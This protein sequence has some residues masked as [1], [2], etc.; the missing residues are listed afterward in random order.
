VDE[1][2]AGAVSHLCKPEERGCVDLFDFAAVQTLLKGGKVFVVE[3]DAVAD[4][5]PIAAV[6]RY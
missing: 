2:K 6:F 3:D 5:S 4:G 1:S